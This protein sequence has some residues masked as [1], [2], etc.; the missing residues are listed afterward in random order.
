MSS[1]RSTLHCFLFPA[2]TRT[3]RSSQARAHCCLSPVHP[4]TCS[5]S[6]AGN[7][8]LGSRGR[9]C[10][11]PGGRIGRHGVCVWVL[12]TQCEQAGPGQHSSRQ[13]ASFS[14]SPAVHAENLAQKYQA[15]GE[16]ESDSESGT[17]RRK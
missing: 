16:A 8:P 5:A 13:Q 7:Q 9:P 4:C 17:T 6:G 15:R 1:R 11:D 2:L 10:P 14:R 12:D 3:E